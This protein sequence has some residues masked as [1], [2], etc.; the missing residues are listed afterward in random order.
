MVYEH[1]S[2]SGILGFSQGAAFIPV[3]LANTSNKFDMA[4][5]FNG[6]LPTTHQGLMGSINSAAPFKIPS[7]VFSG[8]KDT[9]FKDMAKAL[10][11]KFSRSVHIKSSVAGHHLPT[12]SDPTFT[13]ILD[14]ISPPS[15]KV[16]LDGDTV[17]I[18]ISDDSLKSVE[19][20]KLAF[21]GV[22]SS[23]GSGKIN[24]TGVSG[25]YADGFSGC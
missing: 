20:N 10:A 9:D 1:G 13:Q 11:D 5:M 24:V 6:Y 15:I 3:Y 17:K 21:Y 23:D 4:L 2:F 8:D 7:I 16:V 14:F 18:T 22:K 19:A 12:D 25:T